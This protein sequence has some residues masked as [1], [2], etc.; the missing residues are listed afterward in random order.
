MAKPASL[1]LDAYWTAAEIKFFFADQP[2]VISPAGERPSRLL[3][4]AAYRYYVNGK[5]EKDKTSDPDIH[6]LVEHWEQTE[7]QRLADI[8]DLNRLWAL[9][10]EQ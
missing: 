10:S 8:E 1:D 7:R 4:Y 3:F 2:C 9:G 5:L 6:T